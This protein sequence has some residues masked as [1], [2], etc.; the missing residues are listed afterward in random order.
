MKENG[1]LRLQKDLNRDRPT[2]R[3]ELVHC[4]DNVLQVACLANVV[5]VMTDARIIM[6]RTG[7]K[8]GKEEG[9]AWSYLQG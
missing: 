5:W 8:A 6:V 7:V 4:P 1:E 3:S 2:Y 9:E